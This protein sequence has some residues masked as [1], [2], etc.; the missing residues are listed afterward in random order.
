MLQLSHSG[1]CGSSYCM[2]HLSNNHQA[3]LKKQGL[4]LTGPDMAL[5]GLYSVVTG[6]ERERG[7]PWGSAFIGDEVG[8]SGFTGSLFIDECKTRVEIKAWEA[9]EG[10]L[11]WLVI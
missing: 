1:P 2:T 10:S 9:K 3:T 4:F 11:K 6:K 7:R 5:L 8:A